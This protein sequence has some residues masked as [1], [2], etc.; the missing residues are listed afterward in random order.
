M[1]IKS[2]HARTP[3]RRLEAAPRS[4]RQPIAGARFALARQL[5]ENTRISLAEIAGVLHH[6][7]AAALPR[8]F[9]AWAEATRRVWRTHGP[10]QA[11]SGER[12]GAGRERR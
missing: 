12:E 11:R 2:L 10:M 3:R 6:S 5:V 7:D 8:A 4:V 1:R 9:R